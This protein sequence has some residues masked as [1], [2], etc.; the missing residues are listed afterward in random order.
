MGEIRVGAALS[1]APGI[2][3]WPDRA[4][5]QQASRFYAGI[6][7]IRRAFEEAK[8]DVILLVCNEHFVNFYLNNMPAICVGIGESHFGPVEPEAWLRIPKR[9]V[10]GLAGAKP[11]VD[12]FAWATA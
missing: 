10:P 12:R 3:G 4:D 7:K 6:E 1:H 5:S 8:P 11:P 2:T 9:R